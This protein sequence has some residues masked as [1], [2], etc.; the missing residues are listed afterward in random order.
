MFR[1]YEVEPKNSLHDIMFDAWEQ[2]PIVFINGIP[3]RTL[4]MTLAYDS[5]NDIYEIY[6]KSD[7]CLELPIAVYTAQDIKEVIAY[8]KIIKFSRET[9]WK[10]SDMKLSFLLENYREIYS[11]TFK[12]KTY[13]LFEYRE[14]NPYIKRLVVNVNDFSVWLF[15]GKYDITLTKQE[16]DKLMKELGVDSAIQI[17]GLLAI[18]KGEVEEIKERKLI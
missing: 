6:K 18:A 7:S 2:H 8:E 10:E 5:E 16:I 9:D 12:D 1:I 3:Y 15:K 11:I 4:L 17:I 14:Y 13:A